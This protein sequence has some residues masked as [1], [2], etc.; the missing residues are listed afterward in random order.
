SGR[1]LPGILL[2]TAD[3]LG[4]VEFPTETWGH[5][6]GFGYYATCAIHIE[7][8]V[9]ADGKPLGTRDESS[10]I[11]E[12]LSGVRPS[13]KPKR[14]E[15]PRSLAKPVI[16]GVKAGK[17]LRDLV[18]KVSTE[19]QGL[20]GKE[21]PLWKASDSETLKKYGPAREIGG[22]CLKDYLGNR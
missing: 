16:S 6:D 4:Y 3:D 1:G 20:N 19:H 21:K 10:K 18:R 14:P 11:R 7:H 17:N 8:L 5:Y 15:A 2:Y 13:G 12:P 9:P 22:L